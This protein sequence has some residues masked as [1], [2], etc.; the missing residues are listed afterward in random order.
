M[1]LSIIFSYGIRKI[2]YLP[3]FLSDYRIVGKYRYSVSG[4]QSVIGWGMRP[5]SLKARNF[6]AKYGLTYVALEDGFLRSSGLGL[7][8]WPPYSLV[9]DDLGIYYD[10]SRVSRLE[11][12][13]LD[14]DTLPKFVFTRADEAMRLIVR[15]HLS[16]Y[17]H[18]ADVS[19]D[20][21]DKKLPKKDVVLLIDQTA[22]DMAVKYGGADAST[23][24]KMFRAAV[25][26]NPQ[27]EIWVKTHPDVLCG[28]K[29]GYLA[30]IAHQ[31]NI[32]L[33]SEDVNPISLLKAV[34]RVYCVTSQMG[35][36]ALLCGKPVTVFGLPWY[37]GWGIT[38]D[39]HPDVKKLQESG[40]R[41]PR[42][43]VQLFAA[44]Y[45]QYCRYINPNTGERGS[46][47]DVIDYLVQARR[48]NETLRGNL[49]CVG[50]SLWK[51]AVIKP[52][53]NTPACRV[54]FVS[55]LQK[56]VK[57]DL[58]PD[59]RLL[60]WGKGREEVI[61]F[62][63]SRNLPVL[64]IEDG[65]VRS[66]GL[67]SNLVPPLSLVVDDL[68]IYFDPGRPSRLEDILQNGVF[69]VKDQV[70]AQM[71][72]EALLAAN[73]SK[74][75]VG[76]QDF[77]LPPPGRR[78]LLVP[79]QVEDDASIRCG[80]RD[81]SRNI[82][83][84]KIVRERNPDAYIIF[85]PHPDVVSGNRVGEI[86]L[87]E[88]LLYADQVAERA[89]ILSCLEY[90]DEVHTMTS[91]SGFEALLR[92]KK[93]Y[94]Y[95]MPFYAGWGLTHDEY[96]LPRR[97]RRLFL[98]QLVA[99]ALIYYPTYIHPERRVLIDAQ[100][101][102]G[103]LRQQRQGLTGNGGLHRSWLSKQAGKLRQLWLSLCR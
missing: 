80:T 11:R 8:G 46:I 98:W 44:A 84:L 58:P 27:A 97:S 43:L 87:Q 24:V 45:L 59:A 67:G 14:A 101:A 94:C 68:G 95:G 26:E 89:D 83:L 21:G 73:I 41:Q 65:F 12:L 75:N 78:V 16:K 7:D 32:R 10:T 99:G 79:G 54:R 25:E 4:L 48:L 36:E 49:Y 39:R 85:K 31:K 100:T 69:T 56:L 72:L 74:Y 102:V 57:A 92:G 91:L 52:F 47:F 64:R 2:P 13:I 70:G 19:K 93:V 9:V 96:G 77:V 60:A 50:M 23:F 38:D 53:L 82:D 90:A 29:Q 88:C 42:T 37:A 17:N 6:A 5:S 22:G 18:A 61:R 35:F 20:F 30:D 15:H 62:A 81:I 34:D 33:L 86:G 55:S 28:K 66:V 40:R 71:L 76:R 3:S 63:D 51:R 1:R 103:I